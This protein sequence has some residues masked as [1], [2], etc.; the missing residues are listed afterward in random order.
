MQ[1]AVAFFILFLNRDGKHGETLTFQSIL[2][3]II[4]LIIFKTSL[5]VFCPAFV[6]MY[7]LLLGNRESDVY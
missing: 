2:V 5:I 6:I 1:T 3:L 4:S 7:I